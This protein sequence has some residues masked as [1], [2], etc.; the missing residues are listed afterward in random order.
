MTRSPVTPDQWKQQLMARYIVLRYADDYP[1]DKRVD[2]FDGLRL[3]GLS[4]PRGHHV[5]LGDN[6]GGQVHAY[7]KDPGEVELCDDG[8]LAEVWTIR[9][10]KPGPT[11]SP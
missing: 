11:V 1:P 6:D 9:P 10:P 4:I 5:V 3:D 2:R 7:P 8:E